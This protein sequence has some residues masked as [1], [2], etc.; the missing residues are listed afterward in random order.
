VNVLLN[1]EV[2]VLV[3]WPQ[4]PELGGLGVGDIGD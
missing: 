2:E 4:V 3:G 1:V